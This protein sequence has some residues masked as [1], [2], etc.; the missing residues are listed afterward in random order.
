MCVKR[1]IVEESLQREAYFAKREEY[2]E[3]RINGDYL[4]KRGNS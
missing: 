2:G 1:K 3:K 4:G